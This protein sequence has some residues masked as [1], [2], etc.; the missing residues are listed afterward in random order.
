M[1]IDKERLLKMTR[2][3]PLMHCKRRKK[4][5]MR[6][7][8]HVRRIFVTQCLNVERNKVASGILRQQA[9][10][11]CEE[12]EKQRSDTR[13]Q[14]TEAILQQK[15]RRRQRNRVRQKYGEKVVQEDSSASP[16]DIWETETIKNLL[17]CAFKQKCEGRL[18][19][20]LG[21]EGAG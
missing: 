15:G 10:T 17:G 9:G 21:V 4:Y 19:G 16:G 6:Q 13:V 20:K 12:A 11:C 7:Y 8:A 2:F 3:L 1:K 14:A 5:Y 18:S